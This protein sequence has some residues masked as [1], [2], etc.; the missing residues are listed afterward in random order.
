MPVDGPGSVSVKIYSG[1]TSGSSA[2]LIEENC[3]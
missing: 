3:S 1:I 2:P